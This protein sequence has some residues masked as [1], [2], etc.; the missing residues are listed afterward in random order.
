MVARGTRLALACAVV[1]VVL[2]AST[3]EG[4]FT[5]SSP[6]KVVDDKAMK[7]MMK[8]DGVYLV[9]F[10]APWCG[11]CKNLAP[12]WEKLGKAMK[13]V[14]TVAAIDVDANKEAGRKFEIRSL[15]TIKA[16]SV[17]KGK[18]D[19]EEE[20]SG[21][22]TAQAL[23]AFGMRAAKSAIDFRLGVKK[24]GGPGDKGK[25]RPAPRRQADQAPPPAAGGYY[26][27]DPF[28]VN[29][30]VKNFASTVKGKTTRDEHWLVK[31]YAPWCG[32]CKNLK[33]AWKSAASKLDNRVKFG[34]INCDEGNNRAVCKQFDV[35]GFP[36]L[37]YFGPKS[38][39]E[40]YQGGR[41][42]GSLVKFAEDK[43]AA[44]QKEL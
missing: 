20:F 35:R 3:C 28:V 15:P 36:T 38:S 27:D 22:R 44:F 8:K 5:E 34:A 18:V 24:R 10:F 42:D 9:K 37:M 23:A 43:L 14:G 13:G 40:P 21:D 31:F 16:I 11:H 41:D 12:E 25:G 17:T 32:H 33:P 26:E 1:S 6:V 30:N 29:V 7:K 4:L 39:P 19:F 2:L